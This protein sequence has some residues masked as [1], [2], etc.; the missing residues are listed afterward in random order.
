MKKEKI[1]IT[2]DMTIEELVRTKPEAVGLLLEA[3]MHC[4]GCMM[5]QMESIEQGCLAHGM[6]K[7]EVA[8]LI[9]KINNLK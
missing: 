9:K 3:G 7:K 8:E 2:K 1:T 4:I 6:T 5:S